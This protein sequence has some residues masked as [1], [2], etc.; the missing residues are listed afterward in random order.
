VAGLSRFPHRTKGKGQDPLPGAFLQVT[1]WHTL[2]LSILNLSCPGVPADTETKYLPHVPRALYDRA[3][4][5]LALG[6]TDRATQRT[7]RRTYSIPV[8]GQSR[9]GLETRFAGF[10]G[11][12][13]GSTAKDEAE[14]TAAH[15]GLFSKNHHGRAIFPSIPVRVWFPLL[16]ET[17]CNQILVQAQ[18]LNFSIRR[19]QT[20]LW[21]FLMDDL[22]LSKGR[23][24]GK[25]VGIIGHVLSGWTARPAYQIKPISF[26]Q[27]REDRYYARHSQCL[28][29]EYHETVPDI[30]RHNGTAFKA[31]IRR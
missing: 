14:A 27:M 24:R 11:H 15:G 10:G 1:L 2:F 21:A 23:G 26:Y 16:P 30:L 20:K 5:S 8:F 22:E 17:E 7:S 31:P 13:R 4:S 19:T 28:L 18:L 9:L 12:G 3:P 29:W 6:N 25:R